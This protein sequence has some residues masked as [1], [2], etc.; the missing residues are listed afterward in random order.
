MDDLSIYIPDD[1][2]A[3]IRESC[4]IVAVIADYVNLTKAGVN[5]RGLCPFHQEKTPSFFVNEAKKIFHCFGCGAS[6]DVF[7]FIMKHENIG[8]QSAVRLL[9]KRQ[10]IS[11]PEKD[12]TPQQ[13][14][15]LSEREELYNLNKTAAQY[16]HDILLDDRRGRKAKQYLEKRGISPTTIEEYGLGFAPEGWD[17]LYNLLKSKKIPLLQAHKVGLVIAK[18]NNQY[19][20]RFRDRIIFPICN[21]S[22]NIIGF[23]GRVIDNGEPKYLNSPESIIYNKRH[24]LYGVQIA[25]KFILQQQEAIVVEGYFD[26][27]TLHQA[28]IKNAVAPLGTALTEQQ[29]HVL[30]RYTPHIVTVFDSDSSGEKA[31]VRSLSPFLQ[32]GIS[33]RMIQLPPGHDPDSFIRE[34]GEQDFQ[35]LL[36]AA[37]PLIDFVLEQIIKK[38]Q[39]HTTRGKIN[40]CEE[41]IPVL[42]NII[43]EIERDLYV[44]K[45]AQRLGI[46][47]TLIVSHI[48]KSSSGTALRTDE[49]ADHVI[50]HREQPLSPEENA[51][52]LILELMI[53]YPEIISPVEQH[54]FLDEFT[55]SVFRE[56]GREIC[57]VYHEHGSVDIPLLLNTINNES[58]KQLTAAI[59]LKA[60]YGANPSKILEDCIQKIRLKKIKQKR[61]ETKS[62]LQKAEASRDEASCRKFQLDYQKLIEEEKC[63]QR[64]RI[65]P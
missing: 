13:R 59:S 3:E 53:V 8:F 12:L 39:I 32:S 20:D 18:G 21:I 33:P 1:K 44:Q 54:S 56:I 61:E 49:R 58:L 45:V 64:F 11:L 23:G 30:K 52:R 4:S 43:N 28:G 14:R 41:T 25:S 38:H 7:A 37:E 65:T 17:G 40:A 2:I 50:S 34:R 9:A 48:K 10:G 31:M 29:I 46:R 22:N 51:E 6:G 36:A 19:Y 55:V 62:L 5:Y 27:L 60:G 47:E 42:R 16:Y 35:K 57:R 24:N 15:H 63:I 26:L